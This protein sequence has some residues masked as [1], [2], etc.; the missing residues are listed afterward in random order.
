MILRKFH[1][2]LVLIYQII[3]INKNL[4]HTKLLKKMNKIY[5][6]HV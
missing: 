5:N 4:K 3:M 2:N 6:L 1:K